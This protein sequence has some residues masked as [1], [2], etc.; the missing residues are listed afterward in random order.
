MRLAPQPSI[1]IVRLSALG[2]IIHTLPALAALRRAM[3]DAKIGWLVQDGGAPLLEGHPM[4]DR[5]HVWPRRAM[6]KARAGEK[7][8]AMGA[9]MRELRAQNYETA[10]DFQGLAKSAVWTFL[11]GAERRIGFSGAD[12]REMSSLLTNRKVA[13]RQ[14]RFHVIERNLSLLEPLGI[15]NP[16]VEFPVHLGEAARARAAEIWRADQADDGTGSESTRPLRVVIN[17][18]AGWET[19]QWPPERF[20]AVAAA[21]AARR[22]ARVAIAWGPG[23]EPLV[24]AVLGA[25]GVIDGGG[26]RAPNV[27][28]PPSALAAAPSVGFARSLGAARGVSALPPTSFVELAAVI[29]RADLYVGGDTGPTHIAAALGVPVVSPFGASDPLRN[30]PWGQAGGVLQSKEPACVPCWKTRCHWN[31]KLA[32]L[33]AIET[34]EILAACERALDAAPARSKI[35]AG[36]ARK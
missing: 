6:K 31:E 14:D 2:D 24:S 4:I 36:G 21:L 20:G 34:C 17:P 11:C 27:A 30:G 26:W 19:K 23:E 29:A 15:L 13:F 16:G 28:I 3:P 32:C 18:G 33:K 25:A 22:G 35:T 12:A 1:L 10:I 7:L 5:L 8:A 9:L